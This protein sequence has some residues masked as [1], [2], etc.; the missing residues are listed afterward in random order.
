MSRS[1]AAVGASNDMALV[2][3][4]LSTA[5]APGYLVEDTAAGTRVWRASGPVDTPRELPQLEQAERDE[6]AMVTQLLARGWLRRAARTQTRT[7]QQRGQS[8]GRRR[9]DVE[10]HALSV[11]T[12]ARHALARWSALTAVPTQ[13]ARPVDSTNRSD[14]RAPTTPGVAMSAAPAREPA[15]PP[16]QLSDAQRTAL[17]NELFAHW[18]PKSRKPTTASAAATTT[19][20]TRSPRSA[21][22]ANANAPTTTRSAA[23]PASRPARPRIDSRPR[24]APRGAATIRPEKETR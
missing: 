11:P 15:C 5:E 13:R 9:V 23:D 16:A 19:S 10:G 2:A 14:T 8:S 18:Q 4:V 1:R 17:T 3:Q 7:G 6:A 21:P 22:S 20:S 24:T 12:R